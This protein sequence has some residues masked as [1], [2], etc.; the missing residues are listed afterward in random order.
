VARALLAL[1]LIAGAAHA[2]EP[3]ALAVLEACAGRLD[4]KLDVGYPLI[5]ARCPELGGALE[6]SP[7]AAW[8][9]EG[10][11]E[12]H[13]Q[14]SAAGLRALHDALVRESEAAPGTRQLHPE[15]VRAVLERVAKPEQAQE[16]WWARLKRW[17]RELLT[18]PPADDGSWWRRL[19]G[20]MSIDRAMLRVIAV[21]SI[22]LLVALAVAVVINELRI[23]GFLRRRP[24]TP[25]QG[26]TGG[27][28]GG[29]A[30]L[31]DVERAEPS[32]QPAL[33]LELIAARLAAQDRLPPARAFTVRELTRRARLPDE[34]GR[35]RLAELAA[36]SERVRYGGGAVPEPGSFA[37]ALR[38][39]RELLAALAALET[40]ATVEAA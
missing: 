6:R 19:L 24:A 11:K 34:A 30:G 40:P 3:D 8:L 36:V 21:V 13:N 26:G 18:R 5:A 37:A 20:E 35:A 14:L 2:R 12:P 38:G 31:S 4:P 22:A 32:A 29:G 17:L 15:R 7:Y 1:L 9:P 16:G 39:G 25:E 27:A 10:W 23:A 33:L 28:A